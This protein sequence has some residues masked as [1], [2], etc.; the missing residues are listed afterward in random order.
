M[1]VAVA[2]ICGLAIVNTS[3]AFDALTFDRYVAALQE[4]ALP[5]AEHARIVQL[6]ASLV[7]AASSVTFPTGTAPFIPGGG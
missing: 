3:D 1:Q 7:T 4:V 5:H 6:A 2:E